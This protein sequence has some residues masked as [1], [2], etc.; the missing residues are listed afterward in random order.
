MMLGGEIA[1]RGLFGGHRTGLDWL[2]LIA[3]GIVGTLAMYLVNPGTWS[4]F[5]IGGALWGLAYLVTMP[6]D[7]LLSGR[8]ML[9]TA[10]IAVGRKARRAAGQDVF[11]PEHLRDEQ[12]SDSGPKKGKRKKKAAAQRMVG[13]A[14]VSVGPV[15]WFELETSAGRMVILKHMQRRKRG[16]RVY[17]TVTLEVQG[18]QGGLMRDFEADRPYIGFGR[19]LSKMAGRHQSLI[20]GVEEI[21]RSLPVDMTAHMDWMKSRIS[22]EA[23]NVVVESYGQLVDRMAGIAEQHRSF[24]V[25]K[26]PQTA[27]FRYRAGVYGRGD[28]ADAQVIFDEVRR[29]AAW[30]R[31]TG[32]VKSVR[33]LDE[34]RTAALIRSVQDPSFDL[35]DTLSYV[36]GKEDE[37]LRL[38]DCWQELDWTHKGRTMVN[39]RWHHRC[40]Y[41][42]PD[43]FTADEVSVRSLKGLVSSDREGAFIRTV[44]VMMNL[45][46]AKTARRWAVGDVT[47]DRASSRK[48]QARVSDGT[49]EVLLSSSQRRL[50]DLKPGSGH[51]GVGYG[52][53]VTV[54][55]PGA[56]ELERACQAMEARAS[57]CGIDRIDWMKD[58]QD[59]ALVTALPLARGLAE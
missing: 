48:S 43:A 16:E 19:F 42:P 26:I 55:A 17:F 30:A 23:P 2:V 34:S 52:I 10:V 51:Q 3:G 25:V 57:S 13:N 20:S 22:A 49:S 37:P 21:S 50:K 14:P 56:T 5:L 4:S 45:Y 1:R 32:A 54:S 58:E 29:V 8:S 39:G 27:K 33:A 18:T 12:G 6:I 41:F 46:D 31:N 36:P 35:D 11:T 47:S 40:G 59:T 9:T 7:V 15:R 28:E 53:Y 44:S 24:F 38:N